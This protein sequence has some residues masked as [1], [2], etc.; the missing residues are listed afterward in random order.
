[1]NPKSKIPRPNKVVTELPDAEATLEISTNVV[2]QV[3]STLLAAPDR[4]SEVD[5]LDIIEEVEMLDAADIVEDE[6]IAAAADLPTTRMPALP[7]PRHR[8]DSTAPVSLPVSLP[9]SIAA[10]PASVSIRANEPTRI[11]RRDLVADVRRALATK[12]ARSVLVLAAALGTW[13]F[14][15]SFAIVGT[16]GAVK[17][18]GHARSENAVALAAAAPRATPES[19]PV[20]DSANTTA[21]E[22][23]VAPLLYS[24][25]TST[26]PAAAKDSRAAVISNDEVFRRPSKTQVGVLRVPASVNGMLVDGSPQRVTGGALI[27]ACGDHRIRPPHQS[28][29]VVRVPCGKTVTL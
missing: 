27:L 16:Y 4:T 23:A 8:M 1:M 29:R 26:E 22:S 9:R 2:A 21:S 24:A 6:P 11:I 5:A 28:A 17:I 15:A 19:T 3:A 12:R 18:L 20:D 7:D 14:F 25:S 10:S 13:G